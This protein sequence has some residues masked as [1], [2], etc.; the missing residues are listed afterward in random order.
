M[1]W[2]ALFWALR[3]TAVNQTKIPTLG[4][5]GSKPVEDIRQMVRVLRGRAAMLVP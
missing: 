1:I 4:G 3:D 2:P 5:K